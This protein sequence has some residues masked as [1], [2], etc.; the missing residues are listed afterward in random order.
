MVK[1]LTETLAIMPSNVPPAL[2]S[3]SWPPSIV[4]SKISGSDVIGPAFPTVRSIVVPAPNVNERMSPG[5]PSTR[6]ALSP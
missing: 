2:R 5:C 3:R 6:T 4:Y 1:M